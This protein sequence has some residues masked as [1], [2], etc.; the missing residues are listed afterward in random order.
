VTD[1][2]QFCLYPRGMQA[3]GGCSIVETF[4]FC[5]PPSWVLREVHR[6]VCVVEVCEHSFTE[7][8]AKTA[9]ASGHDPVNCQTE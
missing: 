1:V 4:E 9:E 8:N 3:H 5:L 2:L 6:V 7:S